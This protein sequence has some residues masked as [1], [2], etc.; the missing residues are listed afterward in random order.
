[1]KADERWAGAGVFVDVENLLHHV[2]APSSADLPRRHSSPVPR[3]SRSGVNGCWNGSPGGQV[4]GWTGS[5]EMVL[6]GKKY[7]PAMVAVRGFA[8]ASTR[9]A[10]PLANAADAQLL[11]TLF[12]RASA[13]RFRRWVV[14]TAD[15]DV[16]K[17]FQGRRWPAGW[18]ARARC[19]GWA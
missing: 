13:G 3:T 2:A 9:Y 4:P 7:D 12:E 16:V 5:A 17:G 10:G 15:G 6:V 18:R 11:A 8:G 1:M 14:A 19:A